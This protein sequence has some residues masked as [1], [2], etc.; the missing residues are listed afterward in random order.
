MRVFSACYH[1]TLFWVDRR[2]PT[3]WCSPARLFTLLE[4]RAGFQEE[5]KGF[6]LLFG[7]YLPERKKSQKKFGFVAMVTKKAIK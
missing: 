7:T 1:N 2:S 6:A 5:R 3:A 4:L